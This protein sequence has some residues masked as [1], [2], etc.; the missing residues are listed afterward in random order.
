MGTW[1]IVDA[2]ASKKERPPMTFNWKELFPRD[3]IATQNPSFNKNLFSDN[4]SSTIQNYV[5]YEKGLLS[6]ECWIMLEQCGPEWE[7]HKSG[8]NIYGLKY[9][10]RIIFNL[11]SNNWCWMFKTFCG[12]LNFSKKVN[13]QTSKLGMLKSAVKIFRDVIFASVVPDVGGTIESCFSL[14]SFASSCRS[15]RY[16][17]SLPK[18]CETLLWFSYYW[19]CKT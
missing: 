7:L 3:A 10:L 12:V 18:S 5:N 11:V 1:D 16:L 9:F 8:K 17:L 19:I 13:D 4:T 15:L 14:P 6:I 2:V